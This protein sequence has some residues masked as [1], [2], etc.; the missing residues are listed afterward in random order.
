MRP[1][2]VGASLDGN[3]IQVAQQDDG[4]AGAL[5]PGPGQQQ[6]VAGDD[7]YRQLFEHAR[8]MTAHQRMQSLKVLGRAPLGIQ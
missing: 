6:A 1:V 2:L 4:S 5:L 8:K 3:H 7:L